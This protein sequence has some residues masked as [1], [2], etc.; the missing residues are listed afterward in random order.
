MRPLW[1]APTACPA[2]GVITAITSTPSVVCIIRARNA[3][4]PAPAA[5]L[6]ATTSSLAWRASSSSAISSENA[7]SSCGVRSPYGKRAVSPR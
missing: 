1:V 2:S 7:S 3:V 6:Q 4:S 5:E